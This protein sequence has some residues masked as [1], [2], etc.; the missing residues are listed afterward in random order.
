VGKEAT[1]KL[2]LVPGV[3]LEQIF[4]Y[5]YVQNGRQVTVQLPDFFG[6]Q[7]RKIICKLRIPTTREGK[8]KV[9]DVELLYGDPDTG[10]QL[11][12]ASE[13]QVHVTPDRSQV[14]RGKNAKVMA[15][16]EQVRAASTIN[17]AMKAY[18]RG[19]VDRSQAMLKAQIQRTKQANIRLKSPVLNNLVGEM[20][21]QLEGTAAAA[22][23][24]AR[25]RSLVKKSKFRAYKLAK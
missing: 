6:G 21:D 23:S 1:L 10:K 13:A 2:T 24:S 3:E 25:G 22:P 15:R 11:A 19:D 9:A 4:G 12:V 18:A 16:V 14:E 8:L 5:H 20:D 7:S 17:E